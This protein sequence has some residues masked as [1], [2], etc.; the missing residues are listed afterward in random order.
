MTP[1]RLS[2][3][4]GCSLSLVITIPN[5][6]GIILPRAFYSDT[7]IN[8]LT[9]SNDEILG[10]LALNN[11]FDLTDLQ[12]NTW[13]EEIR[14]LKSAISEFKDGWIVFEYTIPRM[15]KRIDTVVI[16]KGIIFLLE[17]KVGSNS[18]DRHAINQVVDYA[19]DLKYFHSESAKRLLVPMLVATKGQDMT[20]NVG[21]LKD[22]IYN[23]VLCNSSNIKAA[24]DFVLIKERKE[25]FE[26]LDWINASYAPTPT[27]IEAAQALYKGHNVAEISRN[28]ASAIN[29]ARTSTAINKIIDYSKLNSK[30]SICFITGVPG[31][32]K[33]LAGLN[34]AN[35]RHS[36]HEK[37]H[38]VFL[39]GNQ[40]LVNVLQ[41]ALA[42]D[43]SERK[44]ITK[45]EALA[46][47]RAFIQIIHHFRD[48]S[49]STNAAPIEKVAIF[50]EAQRAWT[51][52]QLEKFMAQKKGKPNFNM[53]EPEFLISVMDRHTDW[54]VIICLIGGGQEINTGEAGLTEWFTSL[55][56]HFP[57]WM[58]YLSNNISDSEFI[59]D[60]SL[61]DL[62]HGLQCRFVPELHLSVSMRSFR[63]ENV[64]GFVKSV[65]DVD[66][67]NATQL[68]QQINDDYP[69]VITRDF[70]KAKKWIKEK[71]KGTERY[72]VTA[73]S[74][75]RRL[76]PFGIWVQ[77][78]INSAANWFLNDMDDVRSSY[79]L[80][81]VAT[82]F[83]IQ[84]LELDWT[85]VCWDADFRFENGVFEYYS[86]TG[87]SW[88]HV[89]SE[90]KRIYLKNTY[91]VLLT[92]A[93]Q[94]MIIFLPE[95]TEDDPTR[96]KKY[97]DETYYYLCSIGIKS[98]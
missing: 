85:I 41:E 65:L 97:Y 67:I 81:E 77:S 60:S 32:G 43:E 72:G 11:P 76:R 40:P 94:G 61:S 53:S 75:A 1:L 44:G 73:S 64:A 98:I 36:F 14:I 21:L 6:G 7:I 87:T 30:K 13:R 58:V 51:K 19:L 49:I 78:K 45:S 83:D 92:R 57:N 24:I 2:G 95:G 71:A 46:K 84:G 3:Q 52:K 31:A 80:E 91:R 88:K 59:R 79:F 66:P 9:Q 28:D 34:I 96:A 90:E 27:I 89:N 70:N 4:D 69:I 56:E 74:G 54:A 26:P 39:S 55:K 12:R 42:R 62:I 23:P 16:L 37:E 33:T 50:D 15:G 35:E 63:S 29:L 22:G 68:L 86:F 10:I 8:F 18:Y 93:R 25:F 5:K 17:F 48:D 47:A 38:A 20:S 82:E